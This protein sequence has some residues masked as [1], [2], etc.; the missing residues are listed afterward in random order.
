MASTALSN[1]A[2]RLEP[3]SAKGSLIGSGPKRRSLSVTY[4]YGW[5]GSHVY[6]SHVK[7]RRISN[8]PA[9]ELHGHWTGCPNILKPSRPIRMKT[10]TRTPQGRNGYGCPGV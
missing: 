8:G 4:C 1:G 5:L 2:G 9:L 3:G 10:T 6:N 7:E